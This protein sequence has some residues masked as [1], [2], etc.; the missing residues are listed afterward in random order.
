MK[1]LMPVELI[2]VLEGHQVFQT[3]FHRGNNPIEKKFRQSLA[4]V[5]MEWTL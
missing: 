5:E 1:E 3:T 2:Q 4:K